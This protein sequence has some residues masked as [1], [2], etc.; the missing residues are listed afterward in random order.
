MIT[1][2]TPTVPQCFGVCCPQHGECA[3]YAAM[4][5]SVGD[6]SRISTCDD[7]GTG[8]RPLFVAVVEEQAA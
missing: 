4:D 2:I 6:H 8:D 3:R 1:P 5:G 7:H